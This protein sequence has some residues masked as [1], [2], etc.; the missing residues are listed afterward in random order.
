MTLATGASPVPPALAPARLL[1]KRQKAAIVVRLLRAEGVQISLADLPD[2]LQVGLIEDMSAMRYVDRATLRTVIEEFLTEL[3]GIGL[4]FPG[5]MTGA[6]AVL[7][8]TVSIATAT[9]L[10]RQSG[11]G[12]AIDPWQ[13]LAELD[14]ERLLPILQEESVEIGAVMLSK[15]KVSKSAEL[16]GLLPGERARRITYAVSQTGGIAPDTVDKIG[17]A[18]VAQLD[19]QAPRAFE[20]E[21]VERV[22]A[23]LNFSP[24]ATRNA[25]LEGLDDQDSGFADQVRRAIF[26]F[27]NIPA[28]IDPRDVPKVTREVD[29]QVL[30]TA[31]AAAAAREEEAEAAE[32]VLA[33]MSQRMAA[34]LRDEMEQKGRI[35]EKDGEAA[36]TSVIAAIRTLEAAGEIL[37]TA[38]D[39]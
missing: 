23:I 38:E 36:M 39:E 30:I 29:A 10:R 1:T 24:A 35:K 9:R 15:L 25:V 4:A 5:G 34:Q 13:R 2:H 20:D 33:N 3:D 28:R 19:A 21:P 11:L 26:T 14:A 6:L 12:S 7:D 22:G 8:G 37:L 16:L 31:L 27:A 32:F 18:L 17:A